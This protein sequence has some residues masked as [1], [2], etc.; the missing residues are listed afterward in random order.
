MPVSNETGK[1]EIKKKKS[2]T[3]TPKPSVSKFKYTL[4]ALRQDITDVLG[5]KFRVRKS[6]VEPSSQDKKDAAALKQRLNEGVERQDFRNLLF[7]IKRD[8]NHKDSGY[9]WITTEFVTRSD[10]FE[11]WVEAGN[12]EPKKSDP[13]PAVIQKPRIDEREPTTEEIVAKREIDRKARHATYRKL[14]IDGKAKGKISQ[15]HLRLCE[16]AKIDIS[17]IVSIEELPQYLANEVVQS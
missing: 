1:V 17:D 8:N 7:N 3:Q 2:I 11:K 14:I 15:Y 16:M 13:K 4:T 10:M 6:D 12:G 9:K 5:K